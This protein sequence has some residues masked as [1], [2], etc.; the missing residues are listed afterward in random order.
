MDLRTAIGASGADINFN[1]D[2]VEFTAGTGY[3]AATNAIAA[4]TRSISAVW[5]MVYENANRAASPITNYEFT[6][7][8]SDAQ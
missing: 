4:A 8:V 6:R 2:R 5:D 3:A 7:D 1:P